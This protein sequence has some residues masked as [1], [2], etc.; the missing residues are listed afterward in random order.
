MEYIANI[1]IPN[2]K[3]GK[4]GENAISL[5]ELVNCKNISN[6]AG[7]YYKKA[8]EA[9]EIL[10]KYAEKLDEIKKNH[11]DK[12]KDIDKDAKY[13]LNSEYYRERNSTLNKLDKDMGK[14]LDNP[15]SVVCLFKHIEE[16]KR[17]GDDYKKLEA[18]IWPM[19]HI[20]MY[21]TVNGENLL[22][23]V[24]KSDEAVKELVR[25]NNENGKIEIFGRKYIEK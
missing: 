1:S 19:L 24:F 5:L 22:E 12:I 25:T 7:H 15:S 23:K 4:K 14:T 2:K 3:K 16:N 9:Y 17:T 6:I 8:E 10:K 13:K 20:L 18:I 21:K 11:Y